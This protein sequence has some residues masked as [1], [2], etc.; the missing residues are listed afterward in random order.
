[1]CIL[2]GSPHPNNAHKFID[3]IHR[4]EIYAEF[5]NYFGL[6]S[7]V[8]VPARKFVEGTPA[9]SAEDLAR[10][11]VKDDLGEAVSYY[12]DEWFNKIRIGE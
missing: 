3:F 1:M 11:T 10:T 4:P 7:T 12:N 8:N 6:P 2:K 9:Y 5:V